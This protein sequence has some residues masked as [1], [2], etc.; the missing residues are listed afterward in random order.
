MSNAL[1]LLSILFLMSCSGEQE[2]THNANVRD[3]G[4]RERAVSRALE[5]DGSGAPLFYTI[6]PDNPVLVPPESLHNQNG[7]TYFLVDPSCRY[8]VNGFTPGMVWP[9]LRTGLRSA[10][11]LEEVGERLA[12]A[13]WRE[14]GNVGGGN[15]SLSHH[16]RSL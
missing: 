16:V 2:G 14:G 7:G 15:P 8:Y 10:A 4:A 12:F 6:Q 11:V 3:S 9:E 5:C 13:K 1:T